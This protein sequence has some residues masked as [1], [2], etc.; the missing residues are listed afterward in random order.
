MQINSEKL[1]RYIQKNQ[2]KSMKGAPLPMHIIAFIYKLLGRKTIAKLLVSTD[3]CNSCAHCEKLCPH[4]A[5]VM[6]N[7]IPK[8]TSHC[9][10]CFMCVYACPKQAFEVP[11]ITIFGALALLFLPFDKWIIQIFNLPIKSNML[12]IKYQLIA[13]VLWGIG[14]AISVFLFEKAVSIASHFTFFKKIG[15]LSRIKKMRKML[16]PLLY[17]PVLYS[18][19]EVKNT[20][21]HVGFRTLF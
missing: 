19:E 12:S 4:N 15:N 7:G 10:G 9:K 13:L 17:F 18:S 2:T 16:N 20:N 6:K 21:K 14:Y 8:R 11:M 1:R 5:I 3:E